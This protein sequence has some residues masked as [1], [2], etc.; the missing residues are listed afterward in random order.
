MSSK[1]HTLSSGQAYLPYCGV[2]TLFAFGN[3]ASVL[4]FLGQELGG[5]ILV[6]CF[7]PV[8]LL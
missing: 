1:V 7:Q 3:R 6:A 5:F 4:P 2:G 8:S